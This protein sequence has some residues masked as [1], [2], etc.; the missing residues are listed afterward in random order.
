MNKPIKYIV[1]GNYNEYQAY[2]RRKTRDQVYYK[3]V[4]DVDIIR[5]LSEIDGYYIG[6]YA[7]RK[8]IEHIRVHINIIKSKQKIDEIKPLKFEWK[9]PGPAVGFVAQEIDH[10]LPEAFFKAI[11][12]GDIEEYMK[13]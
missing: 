4:S 6:S 13:K 12:G 9:D 5:G 11:N 8:D 3:Y 10:V 7:S 1:A 2:V